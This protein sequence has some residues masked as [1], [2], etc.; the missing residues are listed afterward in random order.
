MSRFMC[1]VLLLSALL[2]VVWVALPAKSAV[3]QDG[4]EPAAAA[5]PADAEAEAKP[6]AEGQSYIW[7][8]IRSSGLIGLFILILSIYF[9]ATVI[10]LFI[11]MRMDVAIPPELLQRFDDM[12][13]R[14]EYAAIYD[15]ARSDTSLFGRVLST[16]LAELP[17]G[18]HDARDAMERM[19]DTETV[20]MEKQI[21][22]LAVLGTLGP[23]I[24][25]IGTLKGMISS[26]SVIAM[27]DVQLKASEVAGGIS[28]ALL[29]TF[30]GVALSIPAIYF[31]AIFRNRVALISSTVVLHADHMLRRMA[32]VARGK[33]IPATE[34]APTAAGVAPPP[35]RV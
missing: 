12:L 26:F 11:E 18:L 16:G 33:G 23:M 24:G 34:P 6:P 14:Q 31:F 32:H 1:T 22:M 19:A 29:L 28:E 30:E 35:L 13:Q 3:A 7:W 8:F 5:A 4:K 25:L 20:D 10:R 15:T 9:V 27:S 2:G 17:G 21:S